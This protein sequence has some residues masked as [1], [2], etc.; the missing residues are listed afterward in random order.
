[1]EGM[2][3]PMKLIAYGNSTWH[4]SV[5]I[6]YRLRSDPVASSSNFSL[7][8]VHILHVAHGSDRKPLSAVKRRPNANLGEK[9]R[10]FCES[11]ARAFSRSAVSMAW[12]SRPCLVVAS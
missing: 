2:N 4:S 6:P 3:T 10:Q 5:R 1:M 11:P 7:K 8:Y 9:D 12:C